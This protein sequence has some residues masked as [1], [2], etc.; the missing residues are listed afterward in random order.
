MP[1]GM[2]VRI[3]VPDALMSTCPLVARSGSA[4]NLPSGA[5]FAG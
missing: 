1:G 4:M 2:I 5:S 3:F